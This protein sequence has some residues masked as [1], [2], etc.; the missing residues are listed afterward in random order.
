MILVVAEQRSGK[1]N[2][3]KW[4]TIVGAQQLADITGSPI[5]LLVPGTSTAGV[6]SELAAA[7]VQEV[8]TVESPA[9]EPYTPDGFTAALEVAIGQLSP[10]HVLLPHTYQT[11]DF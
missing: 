7:K 4:E 8:V 9:L 6:A 2:R 10:K 5:T 1:L 3:A 11:R